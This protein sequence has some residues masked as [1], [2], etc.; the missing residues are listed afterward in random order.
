MKALA[1]RPMINPETIVPTS[2]SIRKFLRMRK[3][4]D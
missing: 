1:I 3:E 4:R 2:G